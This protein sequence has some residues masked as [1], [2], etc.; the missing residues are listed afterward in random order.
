MPERDKCDVYGN[1]LAYEIGRKL[2]T[3]V[4]LQFYLDFQVCFSDWAYLPPPPTN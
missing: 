2:W 4:S 1:L 3:I